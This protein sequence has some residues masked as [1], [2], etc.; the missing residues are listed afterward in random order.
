MVAPLVAAAGVSGGLSLLGGLFQSGAQGDIAQKQMDFQERMSSSAYQRAVEDMKKANLNPALMYGSGGPESA[1]AGSSYNPPNVL[2]GVSSSALEVFRFNMEQ[3]V[4]GAGIAKTMADTTK[5]LQ[6]IPFERLKGTLADSLQ[7]SA[8][9]VGHI[10]D[11]VGDLLDKS[12]HSGPVGKM[13]DAL[14]S[15]GDKDAGSKF[16]NWLYDPQGH[17]NQD[18]K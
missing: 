16:K 8:R 1:P 10:I 18:Y 2:E 5:T 6:E 15:T 11:K 12:S 3:A 14:Q 13:F 17:G 7:S 4:A 9:G